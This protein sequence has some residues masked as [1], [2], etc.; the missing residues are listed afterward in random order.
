[1]ISLLAVLMVLV[2]TYLL[3]APAEI[4]VEA[5]NLIGIIIG[6]LIIWF[7]EAI[8][9]AV[10]AAYLIVMPTIMG[11]VSFADAVTNSMTS[12][13]LFVIATSALTCA[14]VNTPLANRIALALLKRSGKS[15]TGLVF[16]FMLGTALI[17]T[18]ISNV[19][20][21]AMFAALAAKILDAAEERPG[22]SRIGRALMIAI[23]FGAI[24]GGI[25]TP[26]GSSINILCLDLLQKY[27]GITVRFLD[28]M[29]LGIP[30][31]IVL[32]PIFTL[33][34]VW[35]CKPEPLKVDVAAVLAANDTV[36]KKL[37]SEEKKTLV[38]LSVMMVLWIASTWVPSINVT[39]VAIC[40]MIAFFLP[41]VNIFTWKEF[42]NEVGWDTLLLIGSI[43]SLGAA[44]MSSGLSSWLLVNFLGSLVNLNTIVIC[45]L[46]AV[47]ITLLH[48]PLPVSA[49]I[50]TMS[51]GP[52]CELAEQ[53]NINPVIFAI[54]A[55]FMAGCVMI[56]PLDPI[57][58][59][60]Y[61]R[62]YYTIQQL[63][64]VGLI[65]S[66]IWSV[67]T[68]IWIPVASSWLG[69]IS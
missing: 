45:I 43:T 65:C 47:I 18:V 5:K 9:F 30:M 34:I 44:V 60:T 67:L 11:V 13:I 38:I 17:S 40:G 6:V 42:N 54:V 10:S 3:P 53:M 24:A 27:A 58:L 29:V 33:V 69:Y 8:P 68:G 25:A 46:I 49:A 62:N 35:I 66:M 41:G 63:L 52:L 39:V 23:P 55:C 51:V 59:I 28:W 14:F 7:T 20:A 1:M 26:A 32:I 4:S 16:V 61:R 64:V 12:V 56:L 50:M 21:T 48:F 57:P 22:S 36:P 37:T 31:M 15:S 2:V 19:P